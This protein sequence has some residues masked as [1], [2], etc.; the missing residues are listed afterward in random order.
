MR[1]LFVCVLLSVAVAWGPVSHAVFSTAA[2][3]SNVVVSSVDLPDGY[4]GFM[5]P[6]F[7]YAPIAAQCPVEEKL[8]N[9]VVAA[10]LVQLAISASDSD[11]AYLRFLR[12]FMSHMLADAVGFFPGFGYLAREVKSVNWVTM[13]TK[14]QLIDA[15]FWQSGNLPKKLKIPHL[16]ATHIEWFAR[17]IAPIDCWT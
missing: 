13:W 3:G 15:Y 14:M 9:P 12:S 1:A 16:N 17:D 6:L 7:S 10:S 2:L 8:H 4:F 11:P 5:S